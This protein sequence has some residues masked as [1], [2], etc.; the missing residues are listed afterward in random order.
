MLQAFVQNVSSVSVFCRSKCFHVTS[1]KCS[2]RMLHMFSYICCKCMFSIF[3][4]F[5]TYVAMLYTYIANVWF[6]W[7]TLFQYVA[8]GAAPPRALTREQA[9]AAPSA[10]TPPGVVPHGGA[11]SR[12]HMC[13]RVVLPPSL[14]RIG[15]RVLCSLSH[16]D[17]CA[18]IPLSGI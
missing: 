9:R 16:W 14:P 5:Q 10:P 18:M 17:M 12:Q 13:M 4:L 6:N 3:H 8:K 1:C 15:A 7:F 2:T 11:C